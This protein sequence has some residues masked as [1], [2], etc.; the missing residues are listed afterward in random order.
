MILK[1]TLINKIR[2]VIILAES[3]RQQRAGEFDEKTVIL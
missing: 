1:E 2:L 3:A